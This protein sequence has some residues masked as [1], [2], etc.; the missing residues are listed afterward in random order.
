MKITQEAI[1]ILPDAEAREINVLMA[2]F[3]L[4]LAADEARQ[5]ADGLARALEGIDAAEEERPAVPDISSMVGGRQA[6]EG[7]PVSLMITQAQRA[8][9]RQKG[10]SADDIRNMKP[11]EAHRVLGLANGAG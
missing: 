4:T 10:Y 9:L 5:L 6:E 3:R 8:A 7:A 1:T 11:A 2:G